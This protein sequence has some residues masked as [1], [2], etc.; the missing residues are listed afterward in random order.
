MKMLIKMTGTGAD[1][2]TW[3]VED[4]IQVEP[5]TDFADLCDKAGS[6]CFL[7]LVHGK[8]VFGQP[9][10]GCA[11]PYKISTFSFELVQP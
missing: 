6:H 7:K 1:D 8:A 3:R 4:E 9:G 2:Q 11:G 10:V 5:N